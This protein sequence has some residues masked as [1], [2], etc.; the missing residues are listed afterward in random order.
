MGMFNNKT[1][2]EVTEPLA[3]V[4][5]PAD[6]KEITSDHAVYYYQVNQ[7]S[8]VQV[9][10]DYKSESQS[11]GYIPDTSPTSYLDYYL[12]TYEFKFSTSLFCRPPPTVC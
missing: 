9:L 8:Q 4:T 3:S 10:A 2:D 7:Q 1:G 6:V 5:I 11:I 12:G